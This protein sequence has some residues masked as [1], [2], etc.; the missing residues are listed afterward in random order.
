[1]I[2]YMSSGSNGQHGGLGPGL[3]GKIG[4]GHGYVVDPAWAEVDLAMT[5]VSQQKGESV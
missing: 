5:D 4:A 2:Q 1:M 3:S